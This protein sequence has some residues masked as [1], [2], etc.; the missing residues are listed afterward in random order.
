MN[1]VPSFFKNYAVAFKSAGNGI[2]IALKEER[3]L[4]FHFLA[5]AAV[6]FLGAFLRITDFEWLIILLLFA[7]VIS[8]ELINSAIERLCDYV[9]PE[10]N[11]QIGKIKD[12]SA[13]AVL[14]GSI[15]AFIAALILF[16]PKLDFLLS[17]N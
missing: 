8:M 4:R 6:S 3:N 15:I 2:L 7:L 17:N 5:V 16:V 11:S 14:W 12:I 13:G 9:Q 10:M 1:L